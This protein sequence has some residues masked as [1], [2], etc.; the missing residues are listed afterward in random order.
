MLLPFKFPKE[1][2]EAA[3]DNIDAVDIFCGSLDIVWKSQK[4]VGRI[5]MKE[6]F[7]REGIGY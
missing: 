4:E 7:R 1:I 2:L 3:S 5:E 6:A